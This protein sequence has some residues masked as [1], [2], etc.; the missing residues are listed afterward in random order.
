[1]C[2]FPWTQINIDNQGFIFLCVCDAWVPFAVGH[3]TDFKSLDE[4]FN[5]PTASEIQQSVIDG[6]YKFCDTKNCFLSKGENLNDR[7]YRLYDYSIHLGIDASCNLQCPSCRPGMIFLDSEEYLTERHNWIDIIRS[8][9][10]KKPEAKFLV[11]VGANGEP[12]ASVLFRQ[13]FATE[14][15][16]N[17]HYYIRSNA[18]LIKKYIADLKLL[19]NLRNIEVSLD[20]A[21][22]GVYEKVRYPGKWRTVVENIDYLVELRKNY[23]FYMNASFVIQ[24]SNLDDVLPFVDFCNERGIEPSFNLLQDWASFEDYQSE[25]VHRPY[26]ALHSQF[27]EIISTKEFQSTNPHWLSNYN[28]LTTETVSSS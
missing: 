23:S 2:R 3:V 17:V 15:S 13:F 28:L 16:S 19:S 1:M 20:A 18:T 12:F 21:S 26:D 24:R 14:F 9:I 10:V 11:T 27:L 6:T 7:L 5:S 25:C 8:W 22:A 4:I